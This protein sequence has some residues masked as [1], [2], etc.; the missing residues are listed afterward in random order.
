MHWYVFESIVLCHFQQLV[1]AGALPFLSNW[2]FLLYRSRYKS[3]LTS[4]CVLNTIFLLEYKAAL[5]LVIC[6]VQFPFRISFFSYPFREWRSI[7]LLF[8]FSPIFFFFFVSIK[9]SYDTQS[10]YAR[11]QA[12]WSSF[13]DGVVYWIL[14]WSSRR[15]AIFVHASFQRRLTYSCCTACRWV[16][17]VR[18]SVEEFLVALGLWWGVRAYLLCRTQLTKCLMLWRGGIWKTPW[19]HCG[20]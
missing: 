13:L 9:R 15:S 4:K 10:H 7:C 16:L 20:Q 18:D 1:E 2:P 17:Y 19:R 8:S 5:R 14:S 6:S 11:R 3:Y 12:T